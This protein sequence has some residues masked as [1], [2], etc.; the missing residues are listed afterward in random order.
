[1][2]GVRGQ[3]A[4]PTDPPCLSLLQPEEETE[5]VFDMEPS[6]TSSTP[7]SLVSHPFHPRDRS[8]GRYLQGWPTPVM[9]GGTSIS[10]H[11]GYWGGGAGAPGFPPLT[12]QD[13]AQ[14]QMLPWPWLKSRDMRRSASYATF[15]RS[16][17]ERR[18]PE[19][20]YSVRGIPIS[21][22]SFV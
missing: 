13:S 9:L 20:M 3:R 1:M 5:T 18:Q 17:P 15:L 14:V 8:G 2:W 19:R 22:T 10:A 7:T 12:Q 6:S 21:E 16:H 11:P 4:A